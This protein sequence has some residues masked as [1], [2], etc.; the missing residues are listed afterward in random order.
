MGLVNRPANSSLSSFQTAQGHTKQ[1]FFNSRNRNQQPLNNRCITGGTTVTNADTYVYLGVTMNRNLTFEPYLKSIIQKVYYKLYLFGKIRYMLTLAA[2][3]L[4]YKQ[5]VLPFF[6][7]LDIL[8]DS[9]LKLH[10]DKLRQLQFRG[11]KI[12]YQYHVHGR[13]NYV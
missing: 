1:M 11:I 9:G 2:A 8:I 7:F 13:K 3:I 5:M 12:I 10:I 4:V 6:D